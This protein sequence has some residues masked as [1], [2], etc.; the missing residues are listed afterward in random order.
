M[1]DH[2]V[3]SP[4][5]ERVIPFQAAVNVAH[6]V[7]QANWSQKTW[8]WIPDKQQVYVMAHVKDIRGEFCTVALENGEERDIRVDD[9][10]K[11]NPPKFDKVEDMADLTY[12]NEPSVVHNLRLRYYSNMIYTY[13]GLFLVAINPYRALPI[14]SEKQVAAYRSKRRNEVPPHIFAV[15]DN[16]YQD[17]VTNRENQSILITGE[18]GAGKTENTKKVIQ[19]LTAIASD[20]LNASESVTLEAKI[21][22]AN[23]LLESFGNAQTIRNNNSSRFGKFIRIEFSGSGSIAGANIE[24]YLLEKSRVT[25]QTSKE[26]NFHIFYQLL[27]GADSDLRAKLL[28]DGNAS[29]YQYTKHSSKTIPDVDDAHDFGDLLSSMEV[30]GFGKHEIFDTLRIV[31]S[32]LH[33]GNIRP[34]SGRDD[35]AQLADTS[36]VERVCHLL[37]MNVTAFVKALLKPQI[38]AGKES[39][40]Q[41]RSCEQVLY[42]VEALARGMYERLF[43]WLVDRINAALD[44]PSPRNKFI[45]VLDIAGFEIFQRNSFEQLL[46]NYTNEKLQ[47]FFNHHMFV[48]EQEEYKQ[49]NIEWQFIDFGL[50]LQPTI[51]LIEK[52]TPVG[53]LSC[54]DEECVFPQATDRT[55]TEKL[56]TLWKGKST[57][58]ETPKLPGQS[59]TL[60]HYAARVEYST[61][62]WLDKNKD[63]LNENIT[64]LLAASSE[65]FVASMFADCVGDAEENFAVRRSIV[66][67][68]AFRTVAQRHKEQLM[69]LMARL[70]E[71]EPHFVRCILPNEDKKAGKLDTGLVLDQL[72]CNGV[73]E[74]IRI[75][76]AGF[77]NRLPF[78][79]F[80]GRYEVLCPRAIPSG[81]VDGRQAAERLLD[82]LL[83]AQNQYRLGT[84]KVFFRAGVLADL[85]ERRDHQL[86]AIFTRVQAIWRGYI[87]RKRFT[88]RVLQLRAI[89]V[90]QKNSRIYVQLREW[91]WWRLYAKV[92]PLLSVTR[93][94]NELQRKEEEIKFLSDNTRRMEDEIRKLVAQRT[95]L[96]TEKKQLEDAVA[97][98]R[99][100]STDQAAILER[101]QQRAIELDTLL[102]ETV[103]ELQAKQAL[104]EV[105]TSQSSDFEEERRRL[106]VQITDFEAA[107]DRAEKDKSTREDQLRCLNAD[108]VSAT[109]RTEKLDAERKALEQ[110]LSAAQNELAEAMAS[111]SDAMRHRARLTSELGETEEKLRR[112]VATRELLDGR[113]LELESSLRESQAAAQES[114]LL[115][116][117]LRDSITRKETEISALLEKLAAE[118]SAKDLAELAKRDLSS[119]IQSLELHLSN[120]AESK[121]R[122]V[123]L[124]QRLESEVEQLHALMVQK[125][126]SAT[127]QSELRQLRE[128]EL[129]DAKELVQSLQAELEEARRVWATQSKA[130]QS[131][132]DQATQEVLR[133]GETKATLEARLASL[134]QDLEAATEQNDRHVRASRQALADLQE[135]RL[136]LEEAQD[137]LL[138]ATNARSLLQATLTTLSSRLDEAE[139]SS[140]HS[141]REAVSLAASASHLR[142][143]NEDLNRRLASLEETKRR[144]QNTV[145]E[146]QSKCD[147]QEAQNGE[148]KRHLEMQLA[149]AERLKV[150]HR[151]EVQLK[152]IELDDVRK[153]LET[154]IEDLKSRVAAASATQ[155]SL[156]KARNRL[157]ADLED[158]RHENEQLQ[159]LARQADRSTKG[160]EQQLASLSAE[161]DAERRH[162]ESAESDVRKLQ[163]SVDNMRAELELKSQS[164][165]SI[166]RQK[167]DLETELKSLIDEIGEGGKNVHELEK[168]LRRSAGRI[169]ELTALLDDERQARSKLADAKS[170][171]EAFLADHRRK[172]EAELAAK[173]AQ[174]EDTRKILLKEIN[175]QGE[176]L[177]ALTE[178]NAELG[179]AKR[180]LQAELDELLSK[181]DSSARSKSDLERAKR[182]AES[183]LKEVQS[184]LE[185]ELRARADFEDLAR[186][187]EQKANHAQALAEQL[188][189]QLENTDRERRSLMKQVEVLQVELDGPDESSRTSLLL[190]KR[191]WEKD[192]QALQERIQALEEERGDLLA[193]QGVASTDVEELKSRIET[194][195]EARLERLEA[196]K[197]ALLTAQRLL[198]QELDGKALEIASFDKQRRLAQSE[199]EDLRHRLEIEIS[200]KTEEITARRRVSSE[201]RDALDKCTAE[202]ARS[203]EHAENAEAQKA[204]AHELL[205]RLEHAE[206]DRTKAEK[207]ASTARLQLKDLEESI[208]ELANGRRVSEDKVRH[209]EEELQE[210][211]EL[212]EE[213]S[214]E[215]TEARTDRDRSRLELRQ[216][217][218]RLQ[219]ELEE[220][221]AAMESVKKRLQNE[222]HQTQADLEAERASCIAMRSARKQIENDLQALQ[223]QLDAELRTSGAWRREK[224]R[225]ES[226]LDELNRNLFDS[227][228]QQEDIL[229]LQAASGAR[230]RDLQIAVD[231]AEAQK[232]ILERSKRALEERLEEAS[233]QLQEAT[234][235]RQAL[236][237]SVAA[238]DSE[239]SSL[240]A[241]LEEQIDRVAQSNEKVQHSEGL[242]QTL[243][244]ELST[245]RESAVEMEREK[246]ALERQVKDLSARVIELENGV[247][248]DATRGIARLQAQVEV[249]TGQL[250]DEAREKSLL[251]KAIRESERQVRLL[252]F[253]VAEKDKLE[254]KL[255][256]DI[257]K[258][259]QKA[260]KLKQQVE[261]LRRAEREATEFRDR[262][263]RFEKE[264]ERMRARVDF[265]SG[266]PGVGFSGSP[267]A[268]TADVSPDGVSD[269]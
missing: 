81:F 26:R 240:R 129:Y 130:L 144:L 60:Q 180:K 182:A 196:E 154:E 179:R 157:N 24:R 183:A 255:R 269:N 170:E 138:E 1:D 22:Q 184:K 49:E 35:Q 34:S 79:D 135:T 116:Q 153:R 75:C 141:E 77:P 51:D 25:H 23:P 5:G 202:A 167:N 132:V 61:A 261:H 89:K 151:E 166:Q 11:C 208:E 64:N 256:E 253:Q 120:E 163:A 150:A 117:K 12:L 15:A 158:V 177:E 234:R 83:L 92:K 152:A 8:V 20:R 126:D 190:A 54:L 31:S 206:M 110:L 45:G 215:T 199:M 114:E 248:S 228:K 252:S 149:T 160:L 207:D 226:K 33:L 147:E 38:R 259:D 148:L 82:G 85:E 156:E 168:S 238:L 127:K 19:Y 7:A 225:L 264:V 204:K 47:Q 9:T 244:I 262:A 236:E 203:K 55:F 128:K 27:C 118:T 123:A 42:S 188:Q 86:S 189:M 198:Q 172:A 136:R 229:A 99:M 63:P 191:A 232:V 95:V 242:A 70:H 52:S 13:S 176:Q 48:L 133:L 162:K 108:V 245:E 241:Q 104:L 247:S 243:Q 210:A 227:V 2:T 29:D 230:I 74:G 6:D 161:L 186:R 134:T 171:L 39:V 131:Q 94:D 266:G 41:H 73:L 59:F 222:L 121:E 76:R 43:S 71:T 195:Y 192:R 197:K 18:S 88:R 205:V 187:Q 96:E 218:E 68:G 111:E 142:E 50:D 239:T 109:E 268:E 44:R 260:R 80:R 237:R 140:A 36:S 220:R 107:L 62:G 37:G 10:E 178:A 231:D 105:L 46:I 4:L 265:G 97:E 165:L 185:T 90:I 193:N 113:R 98:E 223:A 40:V 14:Y 224:E 217:R 263:F 173:E 119:R 32:I 124:K 3:P 250:S 257:D 175:E 17:M 102:G 211:R 28:L 56:N 254:G 212:L 181:E 146:L 251:S 67:K 78:A 93:V 209:L 16:A 143:E 221:D 100:A 235:A 267:I 213:R 30:M 66:K 106:L 53:I 219:A 258:L 65:P 246:L 159:V 216:L 139:R 137:R 125:G 194:E 174:M 101:T 169:D 58:Y 103:A 57:K 115:V 84:S 164:Y 249:L 91:L 214:A 69:T 87:A 145:S 112:E 200:A 155:A 122:L 21:L 233:E 201:L 72:R